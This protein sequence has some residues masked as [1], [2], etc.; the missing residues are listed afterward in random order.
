M[1]KMIEQDPCGY[2]DEN[3]IVCISCPSR[4]GLMIIEEKENE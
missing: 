4:F 2:C 1:N 3:S